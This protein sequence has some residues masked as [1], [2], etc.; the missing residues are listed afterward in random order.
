MN[1]DVHNGKEIES[2]CFNRRACLSRHQVR[3]DELAINLRVKCKGSR[4]RYIFFLNGSGSVR[5]GGGIAF[6]IQKR[7]KKI[8]EEK[9]NLLT[10]F[11][12]QLSSRE[13]G[14]RLVR[15]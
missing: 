7:K 13:G 8:E 6:A 2:Q 14:G 12:L 5:G 10:K 4:K 9:F 3:H 15:P 11:R 1:P